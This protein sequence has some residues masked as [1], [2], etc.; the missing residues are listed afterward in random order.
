MMLLAAILLSSIAVGL[1][2]VVRGPSR[3]DGELGVHVV[4]GSRRRSA[5]RRR[6]GPVGRDRIGVGHRR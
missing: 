6:L 4:D 2:R 1:W 5:A 3:Q